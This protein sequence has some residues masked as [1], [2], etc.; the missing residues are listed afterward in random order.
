[1]VTTHCLCDIV[2]VVTTMKM[3]AFWN[4][5]LIH[6][7][8]DG[9]SK[10]FWNLGHILPDYTAHCPKGQPSNVLYARCIARFP[11][12]FGIFQPVTLKQILF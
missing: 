10:H 11:I 7:P 8:V 12:K 3:A 2:P 4:S 1:M 5:S 6:R 9:G